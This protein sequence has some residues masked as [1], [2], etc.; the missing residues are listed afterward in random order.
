MKHRF[1]LLFSAC[2]IHLELTAPFSFAPNVSSFAKPLQNRF[3]T[4]QLR[5][6]GSKID[7]RTKKASLGIRRYIL[8]TVSF[9]PL[10]ANSIGV[11]AAWA[12]SKMLNDQAGVVPISIA[13][14]LL[15]MTP[16]LLIAL[17]SKNMGLGLEF[18]IVTGAARTLLQLSILGFI[19]R[20]IFLLKNMY[21][22]LSY[23]FMMI[24]LAS[25]VAC[26]KSKYMFP[27]QFDTVLTSILTSVACTS[28]FAFGV[29]VRPRPLWNPQYVIPMVGMLLGNSVNG[30]AITMN[31]L[32]IALVEHQREIEL[33]LS[34]GATHLEASSR[35]LREAVRAGTMP[36]LNNMAV[37]GIISIPGMM[38]G[39]ILGGSPVMQAA[40][41]QTMIMYLI[42]VATFGAILLQIGV[43]LEIG[44]DHS[45]QMLQTHRFE[46]VSESLPFWYMAKNS[47]FVAFFLQKLG[48]T[49]TSKPAALATHPDEV[50]HTRIQVEPLKEVDAAM[51]DETC[52]AAGALTLTQLVKSIETVEDDSGSPTRTLFQDL[53]FQ[54][55]PGEIFL[56][57]GPSGSGK[58]QLLRSIARLSPLTG[59]T[60]ELDG[61]SY[62]S[63]EWRKRI[64]YVTQYKVDIPGS[65]RDFVHRITKFQSWKED[66][67]SATSML[68]SVA[69]LVDAWGLSAPQC[70]D[71]DWSSLSG[72]EAQ[73]VLLAI[74][75]SSNP[76]VLL[77]DESTSALDQSTKRT[78]EETV[79]NWTRIHDWRTIWVSHDP[80]LRQRY[81]GS[82]TK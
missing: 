11:K 25:N 38:T 31:S 18:S 74:A 1:L 58:S 44:F 59:G 2:L 75:L 3:T 77:L 70:L 21:L 67:P 17:I 51:S 20:P 23:C 47:L 54:V 27:G 16:L 78:V 8:T 43:I 68:E 73:R 29:I 19:L 79:E 63:S 5:P 10:V 46:K 61:F 62:H 32:C 64:R 55:K 65:P 60:I 26:G 15:S 41:Y 33:N 40:R 13:K 7:T 14:V 56:V 22:V 37:I 39:Q 45:S 71:K 81:S 34:F 24:I 66:S 28:I 35:L 80:G 9:F 57:D 49:P 76:S 4:T 69:G 53:S 52:T 30:I 6:L 72:G 82:E 42:A 50:T 12:S 36:I 48:S